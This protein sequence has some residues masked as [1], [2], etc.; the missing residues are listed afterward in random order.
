M[1]EQEK[2]TAACSERCGIL[3]GWR[4]G[5]LSSR[6]GGKGAGGGEI[7][8]QNFKGGASRGQERSQMAN[9]PAKSTR[10]RAPS[11]HWPE[12]SCC[13]LMYS[14]KTEWLREET[15][16]MAVDS[17]ARAAA[18]FFSSASAAAGQSTVTLV[19]PSTIVCPPADHCH[20]MT[21]DDITSW[22]T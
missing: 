10:L 4:D 8:G 17:T 11:K 13:P 9:L 7:G 22:A 2:S 16:F 15:A 14:V 18:A 20:P 12:A 5:G 1:A 21:T 6:E 3:D 19:A